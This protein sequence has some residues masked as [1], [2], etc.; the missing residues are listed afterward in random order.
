MD[1]LLAVLATQATSWWYAL[2]LLNLSLI[3]KSNCTWT[4]CCT[5]SLM[6]QVRYACLCFCA[7][8]WYDKSTVHMNCLL[9]LSLRRQDYYVRLCFCTCHWYDKSIVH[10]NCLLYWLIRWQD[11]YVRLCFALVIGATNWLFIWIGCCICHSCGKLSRVWQVG[12]TCH[13]FDK[14]IMH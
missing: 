2:V 7:C 8:H 3:W 5:C 10:M 12:C 6:W 4:G 11:Y 13:S 9:Y 14:L 1:C